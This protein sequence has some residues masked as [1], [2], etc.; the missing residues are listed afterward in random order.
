MSTGAP[1]QTHDE[2]DLLARARR[3]DES[4]YRQLVEP[5]RA[6]LHAHCYRMLGSVDDAEDALQD[7]MLRAW[8]GLPRFAGRSSF[9]SWLY[10][11]ATNAS[12]DTIQ[13]R[14]RRTVPVD[15][16]PPS[17]PHDGPGPP[18]TE[19]VWIEPYPDE[20]LTADDRFTAPEA[21]FDELEA[22]ELAFVAALQHLP[23]RQ[24][25]ALILKDVLGF[26]AAEVADHL[27]TTVAAVNSALQR[28]RGTLEDKLPDRSQQENAR[29][30]GDAELR[31][32]VEGYME[33]W[34]RGDVDAV[35]AMLA[36]DAILTMPPMATWYDGRDAIEVFLREFAFAKQ[37]DGAAFVPGARTVRLV[38]TRANGQVALGAYR[39]DA[40]AGTYKP[41]TIQVLTLRDREIVEVTG[42]VT[43][44][45]FRYFDLPAEL[46]A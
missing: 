22:V 29:T 8:R 41:Y 43:P 11:I 37:W 17:D 23:A 16:G 45:F 20:L 3:G 19:S 1:A 32:V 36:E 25:A 34:E 26:S 27:E 4:A 15:H 33:A 40:E 31:A 38:P 46:P 14:P 18:L 24:R 7:A 21:R 12:L 13:R 42:F 9:R 10:R 44:D 2:D 28:A 5:R 35:A 39:L 30:V 6:E